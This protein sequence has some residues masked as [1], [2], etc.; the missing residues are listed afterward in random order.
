MEPLNKATTPNPFD[1]QVGGSHYK[2]MGLQPIEY[3]LA[4]KIPY[5]EGAI[6]KYVSRWREKGGV[7]DLEKAKHFLDMLIKY[8][9][10]GTAT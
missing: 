10:T 4:N 9:T 2:N 3:I 5:A 7:Q 1:D 6:I 8:E